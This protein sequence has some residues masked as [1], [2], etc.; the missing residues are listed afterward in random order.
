VAEASRRD[1]DVIHDRVFEDGPFHR[2]VALLGGRRDRVHV[3]AATVAA[4]VAWLPLLLLAVVADGGSYGP[5]TQSFLVDYGA[6][7]R[8]LFALPLLVGADILVGSRLSAIA[9]HFGESGLVPAESAA[10][11]AGLIDSTRAWCGSGAAALAIVAATAL[12]I[13]A[14]VEG[15]PAGEL[16]RW[17][18]MDGSSSRSL[19]GWWHVWV[20][21]PLLFFFAAGWLWRLVVWTRFLWFAS[22]LP[23]RLAAAH[24]DLAAGLKFVAFSVRDFAPLGLAVGAVFAGA[25][26]NRVVHQGWTLDALQNA[27]LGVVGTVLVTCGLPLLTLT[28]RLLHEW[29][30]GVHAYGR[31]AARQGDAF[32]RRWLGPQAPSAE[33]MLDAPDFSAS[34]D[35]SSYANNVYAMHLVPLDLKSFVFLA[36]ATALPTLPVVLLTSPVEA[37]M[38]VLAR[39]LF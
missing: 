36:V 10:R 28:G 26:A 7:A 31:L 12:V 25:A 20:S 23:L 9:R 34:T 8:C 33:R 3:R 17:H 1:G 35:L 5:S 22:Q 15:V 27:T 14:L 13:G 30:M 29:R 11:F 38:K 32:E 2:L 24:P 6:L 16:P 37:L 4:V 39:F 18:L 19:A 21:A